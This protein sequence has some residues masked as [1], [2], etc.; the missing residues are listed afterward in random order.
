MSLRS[1]AKWWH[2]GLVKAKRLAE[3]VH[4]KWNVFILWVSTLN[5]KSIRSLYFR[6]KRLV[7]K[8]PNKEECFKRGIRNFECGKS[9]RTRKNLSKLSRQRFKTYQPAMLKKSN[10]WGLALTK[11]TR[12]SLKIIGNVRTCKKDS[13]K[14]SCEVSVLWILKLWVS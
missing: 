8:L 7:L 6:T 2:F 3:F 13:K 14:H 12:L 5:G 10:N 9:K 1:D 11:V 4:F